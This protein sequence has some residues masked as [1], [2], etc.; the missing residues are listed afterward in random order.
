MA[1]AKDW[2]T[3]QLQMTK[4]QARHQNIV[5]LIASLFSIFIELA[6]SHPVY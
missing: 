4:E 3:C 5:Y 1:A 2:T 6:L